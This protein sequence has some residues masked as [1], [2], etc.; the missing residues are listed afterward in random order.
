MVIRL[1]CS[2]WGLFTPICHNGTFVFSRCSSTEENL[3]LRWNQV[4][5]LS[6]IVL[7]VLQF[8]EFCLIS[9]WESQKQTSWTVIPHAAGLEWTRTYTAR[10]LEISTIESR[11]NLYRRFQKLGKRTIS[12]FISRDCIRSSL[13]LR[14]ISTYLVKRHHFHLETFTQSEQRL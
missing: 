5:S 6:K 2:V 3:V 4:T 14:S 8:G 13:V 10:A 9:R 1:Y 11:R 7:N 12:A